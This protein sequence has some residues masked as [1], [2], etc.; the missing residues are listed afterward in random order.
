MRF[1]ELIHI[2]K[3]D[4]RHH[5]ARSLLKSVDVYLFNPSFRLV[6]NYRVGRYLYLGNKLF[7]FLSRYYAYR[8]VTKRGCQISFR[9]VIGNNIYFPHPIGI[10]IGDHVVIGN[11]VKIWQQVTLGSHGREGEPLSYP[12]I[13]DE[14]KLFAGAKIFGSIVLES[15]A[16]VGAN[17]V[18]N[19]DVPAG[20]IAVG[21][22]AVIK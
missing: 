13:K 9:S 18:V 3:A 14:V 4:L 22:P 21:I 1:A 7:K 15:K 6:L 2:I 19:K 17:A 11:Q 10:V 12:V 16:V 8:Q 5:G 20:R